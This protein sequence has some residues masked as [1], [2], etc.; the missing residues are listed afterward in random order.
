M[1]E[2]EKS[3]SSHSYASLPQLGH[4]GTEPLRMGMRIVI[5]G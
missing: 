1:P 4:L 2:N 5:K 3:H